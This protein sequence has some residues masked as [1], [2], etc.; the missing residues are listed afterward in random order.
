MKNLLL[1][2]LLITLID[3]AC[4]QQLNVYFGHNSDVVGVND[5]LKLQS[6]LESTSE[7]EGNYLLYGFA[8]TVGNSS[9]NLKLSEKRVDAIQNRLYNYGIDS[10]RI[11]T[12]YKGEVSSHNRDLFY[13]RR[14]EVVFMK[15]NVADGSINTFD[16]FIESVTPQKQQFYL[17]ADTDTVIEGKKGTVVEFGRD[18]LEFPDGSFVMGAVKIELT[19]YYNTPDFISDNLTT[20]SDSF[21]LETGGMI[22]LEAFSNGQTL[23]IK[24]GESL[25]IKFPKRS[26]QAFQPFYGK[27]L[28]D[29]SMNWQTES[30]EKE[31]EAFSV[32]IDENGALIVV[33]KEY[34]DMRNKYLLYDSST[35]KFMSDKQ[36]FELYEKRLEK[37]T[38]LSEELE[39][40]IEEQKKI[41]KEENYV[42]LLSSRFGYFNCDRYRRDVKPVKIKMICKAQD[43][44]PQKA[45]LILQGSMVNLDYINGE[46]FL[47]MRLPHNTSSQVLIIAENKKDRELMYYQEKVNL[48]AKHFKEIQLKKTNYEQL[49]GII[50]SIDMQ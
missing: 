4:A 8:D 22:K 36:E 39:K 25:V 50:S 30:K 44:I 19:E 34:A 7:L 27:R 11:Q 15:S 5:L 23:Q 10:Q 31:E 21:L 42:R 49:K 43:F 26:E 37:L 47:K 3:Q 1:I 20:T 6:F 33:N 28:A 13:S 17:F 2:L 45:Y 14:V 41:D 12:F 18:I 24:S 32:T 38:L 48:Q 35:G 9:Y 40:S 16:D 46:Y 29:G